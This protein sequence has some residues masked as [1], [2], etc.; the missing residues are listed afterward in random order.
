MGWDG[1]GLRYQFVY[2]L[3]LGVRHEE[4][5]PMVFLSK[6]QYS[7]SSLAYLTYGIVRFVTLAVQSCGLIHPST[8]RECL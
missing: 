8:W 3:A 2:L 1:M 5:I 6:P 7:T 4:L